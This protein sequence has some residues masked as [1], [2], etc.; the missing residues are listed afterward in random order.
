M[1]KGLPA[2]A[3]G[4]LRGGE[5]S[6]I[7]DVL[8][9]VETPSLF[10][11]WSYEV[12]DTKLAMETRGTAILQLSLYSDLLAGVQKTVPEMFHVITPNPANQK[13][14]FR[15]ADFAASYRSVRR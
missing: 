10:G 13:Q 7:P 15:V 1:C 6:G 14:S 9:R 5:W 4:L 2:I 3:Q 8:R 12:Y 11:P